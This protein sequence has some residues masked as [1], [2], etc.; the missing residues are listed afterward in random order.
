[1]DNPVY[2]DADVP[3]DEKLAALIRFLKN[4]GARDREH[5][6]QALRDLDSDWFPEEI[7][8]VAALVTFLRGVTPAEQELVR[9]AL[10]ALE[11]KDYTY[12]EAAG[13][14]NR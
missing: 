1:M 7:P 3:D 5:L 6:Q 10:R 9:Q 12:E 11:E 14:C 13:G 2:F 4:L 8:T